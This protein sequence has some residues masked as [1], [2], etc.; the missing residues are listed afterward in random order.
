MVVWLQ[1]VAELPLYICLLQVVWAESL[2]LFPPANFDIKSVENYLRHLRGDRGRKR[3]WDC[4][5]FL[6]HPFHGFYLTPPVLWNSTFSLEEVYWKPIPNKAAN[7][8]WGKPASSWRIGHA[9]SRSGIWFLEEMPA[10]QCG[11]TNAHHIRK[12]QELKWMCFGREDANFY[13]TF[14]SSN[15]LL[16]P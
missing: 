6:G 2:Q 12:Y 3:C 13:E 7:W 10:D 9:G 5:I 14:T 8:F 16:S 15:L 4:I 11:R 1:L